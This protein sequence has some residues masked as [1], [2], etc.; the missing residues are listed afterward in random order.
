MLTDFRTHY[1]YPPVPFHIRLSPGGQF[2]AGFTSSFPLWGMFQ[3]P[4]DVLHCGRLPGHGAASVG[5]ERAAAR[6]G[7]E[8]VLGGAPA[9]L[10]VVRPAAA[11]LCRR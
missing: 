2:T 7:R 5:G 1:L 6:A 8:V 3:S 11:A 10:A 4:A 9:V